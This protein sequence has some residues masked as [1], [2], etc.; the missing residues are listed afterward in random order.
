MAGGGVF[1]VRLPRADRFKE[2]AEMEDGSF[3]AVVFESLRLR[4]LEVLGG[5]HFGRNHLGIAIVG[6]FK[7][8]GPA[9]D[10]PAV[11]AHK[12]L[13]VESRLRAAENQSALGAQ[14]LKAGLLA[15]LIVESRAQR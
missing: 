4:P 7:R 9:F 1:P 13:G 2:V 6:V 8:L 14:N 12:G 15:E 3:G 11:I 10:D 5:L